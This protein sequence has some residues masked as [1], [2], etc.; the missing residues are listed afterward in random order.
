MKSVC[1]IYFTIASRLQV[2]KV[3]LCMIVILAYVFNKQLCKLSYILGSITS[4]TVSFEN[5]N[6]WRWRFSVKLQ[7]PVLHWYNIMN[8][9]KETKET[10]FSVKSSWEVRWIT[11]F[12]DVV[13]CL[14]KLLITH[15]S[16]Y[17]FIN[18]AKKLE[19]S[20][21]FSFTSALFC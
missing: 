18:L 5:S 14:A 20:I 12:K 19:N 10:N 9:A 21:T 8:F 7:S 17:F 15:N 3:S 2:R 6:Y 4:I 11:M 16:P 13:C 1:S